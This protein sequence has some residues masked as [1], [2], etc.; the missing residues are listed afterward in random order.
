MQ[1]NAERRKALRKRPLSVV[2]FAAPLFTQGERWWNGTVAR[3]L[4]RS[5]WEVILPQEPAPGH[6]QPTAADLFNASISGIERADFIVAVLDG[7]DPDSG[8]A[9]ECGYAKALGKKIIGVRTDLR[10]GGDLDGL[11]GDGTRRQRQVNL[12]LS[13]A[14]SA[15]VRLMEMGD[16]PD[17]VVEE[18]T[19]RLRELSE[20]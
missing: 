3:K 18:L 16:T 8:T 20:V 2:Y 5:G 10:A 1:A 9:F 7:P 6:G 17:D 14:C 13:E 12:M 19:A 11:E 15:F 4:R